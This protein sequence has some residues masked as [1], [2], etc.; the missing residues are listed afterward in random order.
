MKFSTP[1]YP[2]LKVLKCGLQFAGNLIE[3]S[4]LR[5]RVLN[6]RDIAFIRRIRKEATE[7]GLAEGQQAIYE[8]QG[9]RVVQ[10]ALLGTVARR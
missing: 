6:S 10:N 3:Q 1:E 4:S 2:S 9:A 7:Y 8:A 5:G